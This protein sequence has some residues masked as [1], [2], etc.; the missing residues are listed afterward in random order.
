MRFPRHLARQLL[1]SAK[2]PGRSRDPGGHA[3]EPL[4][5]VE[6]QGPN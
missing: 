5:H 1:F 4:S 6:S 2:L 3:G